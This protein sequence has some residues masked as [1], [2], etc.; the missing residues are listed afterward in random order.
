[1]DQAID[2]L[3]LGILF[4]QGQVCCAGSRVFVQEGIYDEFISRAKAAFA[5]VIQG[6]PLDPAT[7]IGAQ[8]N[9]SQMKKIASYIDIARAEGASVLVGGERNEEG[10]LANGCFFKPTPVS[11]THLTLP[12]TPYV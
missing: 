8:I 12:T 2:G 10:A 5:K 6:N 9:E 4:N 1:M 7:Q 3:M 11:Y